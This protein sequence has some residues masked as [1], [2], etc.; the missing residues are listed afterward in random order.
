MNHDMAWLKLSGADVDAF[1]QGQLTHDIYQLDHEHWQLAGYCSAQGKVLAVVWLLRVEDGMLLGVAPDVCE[2]LRRRLALF[3]L[4]SDVCISVYPIHTFALPQN[5]HS[6]LRRCWRSA[7]SV[8]LGGFAAHRVVLSPEIPENAQG[9]RL[10]RMHAGIAQIYAA[11]ADTFL[12]QALALHAADGV[13]FTKGCY[14]GQEN[15][16]RLHYKSRNRQHLVLAQVDGQHQPAIGTPI[17]CAQQRVGTVLDAATE[18][19]VCSLQAVVHERAL[20]QSLILDGGG[21]LRYVKRCFD[22]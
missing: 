14:V 3:V 11:T 9:V 20:E 15:V 12:P 10:A 1:L 18:G 7:S 17:R 2:A 19:S 16:A 13:S 22:E 8:T 4:R 6:L 21:N 5:E